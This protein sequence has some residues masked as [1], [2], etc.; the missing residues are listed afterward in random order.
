MHHKEVAIST[1]RDAE[2]NRSSSRNLEL[3]GNINSIEQNK[4]E[5]FIENDGKVAAS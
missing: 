1:S 3:S 4:S 2:D 5:I